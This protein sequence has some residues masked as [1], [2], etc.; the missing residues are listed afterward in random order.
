MSQSLARVPLHLIF[1]TKHRERLITD[2]VR[3]DLHAYMAS[4]LDNAG[5][6]AILI[7]SVEDHT[8]VL[9]ELS[10]TLTISDAVQAVKQES[11]R[12]IKTQTNIPS[13]FAWQSGYGVFAVSPSNISRVRRYI[14][15][16]REH[17]ARIGYQ[18]EFRL[19]LRK[20]SMPF[21]ER[22]VWD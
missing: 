20:H 4:V 21:D 7:N 1:S 5:C 22:Y 8:H 2:A 18:D 13:H 12:W 19:F 17:H 16:Q 6:P 14:D 9:F 3:S 11:S 10:R 15:S